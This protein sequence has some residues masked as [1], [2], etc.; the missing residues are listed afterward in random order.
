MTITEKLKKGHA[1]FGRKVEEIR[2]DWTSSEEAKRQYLQAA[3]E[4]AQ[5]FFTPI[6]ELALSRE[7][8]NLERLAQER[9]RNSA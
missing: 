9:Q 8:V 2:S 4:G 3:Y 1:D 7:Y 6:G 5:A